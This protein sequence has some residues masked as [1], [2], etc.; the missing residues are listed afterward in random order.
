MFY[1]CDFCV[2]SII[3][4]HFERRLISSALFTKARAHTHTH[5]HAKQ[6]PESRVESLKSV[7]RQSP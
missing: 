1:A 5:T 6:K 7:V 4:A 2:A 3:A